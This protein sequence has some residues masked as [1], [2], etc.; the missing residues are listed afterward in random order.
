T[1]ANPVVI[2]SVAH[3]YSNGNTIVTYEVGGMVELNHNIYTINNKTPDTF[4]LRD[5]SGN[6]ING[7]G[8][9]AFTSGG[10]FGSFPKAVA[11]YEG[12]LLYANTFD[13][14]ETFWGSMSPDT[15]TGVPR[16][17]NFTVGSNPVDSF[18]FAL[19]PTASGK[20]DTIE[21]LAGNIKFLAI[22]TFGGV[23]KATGSGTDKPIEPAS[24]LVK[25]VVG[26]GCSDMTPIPQGSTILYMQRG[27]LNLRSF[28]FDV[29]ADNFISV[30]RNLV[31]DHIFH[32]QA[33]ALQ[34]AFERGS[35]D[36]L[37]TAR[38]DGVLAGVSLKA[39]E[40]VS[41]W[42]RHL[43]GGNHTDSSNIVT[44]PQVLSVQT[45]PQVN[46]FDQTWIIVERKIG[47]AA[48]GVTR[49][50]VEMFSDTAFLPTPENFYTGI[51]NEIS[52]TTA[53]SN[54]M[55]EAQKDFIHLDSSVSFDGSSTGST[56]TP[57]A[58]TGFDIVFTAGSAIFVS[59]D[60]GK[61]IW[62]KSINGVGTG[63][64][65]ITAFTSTTVVVCEIIEDFDNTNTIA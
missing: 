11:F 35:P 2:T 41:G 14:P 53:F 26:E 61:Q 65:V 45:N 54:E 21:W 18:I 33:Y 7:L 12:R 46:N 39:K 25:P 19:S 1:V 52:D 5:R 43:I 44:K 27:N 34:I 20:V 50:Y 47:T 4:E 37:W 23:S 10:T 42:H 24:I 51:G 49:R 13:K 40:D 30:D 15:T 6:N 60:V 64:A 9:T 3:G 55:F 36:I 29:L 59:G 32:S 8:F 16:Y 56:L 48:A 63:R 58:I 22:G 17:D 28:E 38:S 62:K 57:A 31:A